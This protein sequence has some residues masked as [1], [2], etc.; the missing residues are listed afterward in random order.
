MLSCCTG[1]LKL[2]H[3]GHDGTLKVVT[4]ETE[5]KPMTAQESAE[6]ETITASK[7]LEEILDTVRNIPENANHINSMWTAICFYYII[8]DVKYVFKLQNKLSA[9]RFC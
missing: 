9:C 1:Q 6:L 3:S 5:G 7:S 4:K 8:L 2:S